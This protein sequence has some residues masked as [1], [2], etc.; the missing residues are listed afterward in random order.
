[1]TFS[2]PSNTPFEAIG[3]LRAWFFAKDRD[4]R[5]ASGRNLITQNGT[6]VE[7]ALATLTAAVSGIIPSTAVVF[8]PSTAGAIPT[9]W[10]T[11]AAASGRFLVG[12]DGGTF[13]NGST[14]GAETIN[15]AHTHDDGTLNTASDTHS[16]NT[17]T[18]SQGVTS[19]T[20][21]NALTS[22]ISIGNDT[23][24]HDVDTGDT[25]T[26]LSSTQSTL[27]PYLVGTWIE[28]D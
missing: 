25:G 10:S 4:I 5:L 13:T 2:F 17:S 11:F 22:I 9:G 24:D 1:M 26:A 15:I 18:S 16:H 19:G 3:K 27:P 7:T 21:F 6:N 12:A 23:H 8:W 20:D 14:G 28:K